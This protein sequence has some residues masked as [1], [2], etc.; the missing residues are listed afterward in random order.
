MLLRSV[1]PVD[2]L[3]ARELSV[4]DCLSK[5]LGWNEEYST[6]MWRPT[7]CN[8]HDMYYYYTLIDRPSC[9]ILW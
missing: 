1:H 4:D 2:S 3:A 7:T 6:S 8:E 9:V 5:L